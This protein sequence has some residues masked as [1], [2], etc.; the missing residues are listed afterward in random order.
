MSRPKD[1]SITF[2]DARIVFRNFAG[3]ER[4]FNEEGKRNFALVLDPEEADA[5]EADGWKV[6]RKPPREE[7]DDWFCFIP[8]TVSFKGRPPR[9][10]MITKSKNRRTTLDEETAELL[11]IADIENVDLIIRPYD[12]E[13]NGN[14][15]RKAYLQSIY[16]TIHEDDLEIKYKDIPEIG[17]MYDDAPL[18]LTSEPYLEIVDE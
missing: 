4:K 17:S 12:W 14:R 5:M 8:V 9:L 13:V 16:V 18:E 10:V 15:G 7:G 6:K 2:E 1:N 11:D 3:E